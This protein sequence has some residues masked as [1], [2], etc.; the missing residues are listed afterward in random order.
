M[1]LIAFITIFGISLLGGYIGVKIGKYI[2]SRSSNIEDTIFVT[3]FGA[4]IG[5]LTFLFPMVVF[6]TFLLGG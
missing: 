1:T 2:I 5:F 4:F 3:H 6:W